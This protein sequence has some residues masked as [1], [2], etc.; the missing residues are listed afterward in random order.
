MWALLGKIAQESIDDASVTI[1]HHIAHSQ[2]LLHKVGTIA[3]YSAHGPEIS[4]TTLHQRL[5][6]KRFV[7]PRCH[8]HHQLSFHQVANADELMP[9]MLKVLEPKPEKHKEVALEDI[10]LILC[11]G[12]AFGTDGSR[13]GQGSGYYDRALESF[14]GVTC[15][16][17]MI[18]QI[19]PTIPHDDHDYPM[20]YLVNETGILPTK[21]LSG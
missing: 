4:L 1:C 15:G 7:Y 13:L 2:E 9:G 3:L 10:D 20:N 18:Q 5:P 14:T 6:T 21:P 19:S 17:A 8:P 16:I 12:L 11:P